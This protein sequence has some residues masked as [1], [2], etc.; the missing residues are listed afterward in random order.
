M[1]SVVRVKTTRR[2]CSCHHH[3][4]RPGQRDCR[5]CHA[6]AGRKHRQKLV[7]VPR[8]MLPV[9]LWTARGRKALRRLGVRVLVTLT[10]GNHPQI[11]AAS[12]DSREGIAA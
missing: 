10:K 11:N 6:E 9:E 7:S 1:S 3:Y 5:W 4:C 2:L 8:E 12:A